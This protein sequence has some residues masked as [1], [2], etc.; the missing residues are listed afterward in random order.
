MAKRP[1]L[2]Q[3]TLVAKRTPMNFNLE[4]DPIDI[5]AKAFE[6]FQLAFKEA[7]SEKEGPLIGDNLKYPFLFSAMEAKKDEHRWFF[8]NSPLKNNQHLQN[9]L[10]ELLEVSSY[11]DLN[12]RHQKSEIRPFTKSIFLAPFANNIFSQLHLLGW[13]SQHGSADNI[14]KLQSKI[15]EEKPSLSAAEVLACHDKSMVLHILKHLPLSGFSCE[16]LKLIQDH[17]ILS[18]LINS[19]PFKQIPGVKTT[20]PVGEY[21]ESLHDQYSYKHDSHSMHYNPKKNLGVEDLGEK[22]MSNLCVAAHYL[23]LIHI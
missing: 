22:T 18:A 16:S 8:E 20:N 7:I 11:D 10:S 23:S 2:P 5:R 13:V 4:P 6:R 1:I 15:I 14:A 17:E 3:E 21:M 19:K 9:A 12:Q